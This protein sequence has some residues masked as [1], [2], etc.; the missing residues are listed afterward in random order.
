VSE[1][2]SDEFIFVYGPPLTVPRYTLYP[3]T[4]DVLPVQVR[5]AERCTGATP[6]PDKAMA[7]GDVV[8]LLV[9]EM[10]PFALPATVGLNVTDKT[11]F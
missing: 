8:A 9:M 6:V 1:V 3:D 10:L 7:A 11:R 5:V 4:V 2:T